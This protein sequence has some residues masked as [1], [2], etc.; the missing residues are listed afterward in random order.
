MSLRA[1]RKYEEVLHKRKPDAKNLEIAENEDGD[2]FLNGV[3]DGVSSSGQ[4]GNNLHC[5]FSGNTFDLLADSDVDISGDAEETFEAEDTSPK[6]RLVGAIQRPKS[7]KP[8]KAGSSQN[9]RRR[10]QKKK[11]DKVAKSDEEWYTVE[12]SRRDSL[13][14][15]EGDYLADV[16]NL[17]LDPTR[18]PDEYFASDDDDEFKELARKLMGDI[19]FMAYP[20]GVVPDAFEASAKASHRLIAVDPRFLRADTELKKLF[21]ARIVENER[22]EDAAIESRQRRNRQRSHLYR[23]RQET[24]LVQPR[25]TWISRA[26]G[27]IMV[28]DDTNNHG[29]GNDGGRIRYYC[30]RYEGVYA[31]VQEEYRS[32]VSS[33]NPNLLVALLRLHPYHVD[34]LLQLSEIFRQMGEPERSGEMLERALH[35][36]E[37]S[38]HRA[39]KPY[40]GSCRLRFGCVENRPLYLAL[41]RYSQLLT[42]RGLHRTALECAKL[43]MNLDPY[44]DPMG[45]LL[46][47]DSLALSS[48]EYEWIRAMHQ[49]YHFVPLEYFPNFAFSSALAAQFRSCDSGK[50]RSGRRRRV[51]GPVQEL[52]VFSNITDKTPLEC[53]KEALLTFP[54]VLRPILKSINLE[55]HE[56]LSRFALFD[57]SKFSDWL[58]DSG[59]LH[60]I[61]HVYAERCRAMWS[62]PSNTQLLLDGAFAAGTAEAGGR[63]ADEKRLADDCLSLRQEAIDFFRK[64]SLYSGAHAIVLSEGTDALPADVIIRD[65][66]LMGAEDAQPRNTV[67]SQVQRRTVTSREAAVAFLETLLPW[68]EARDIVS[69]ANTSNHE[70]DANNNGAGSQQSL[71]EF[72]QNI[73]R[74]DYLDDDVREED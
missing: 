28:P 36:L 44:D 24:F 23:P 40:E 21:G 39:F 38:W 70:P 49:N 3:V 22:R 12:L 13:F 64:C 14:P 7:K 60:R 73:L 30:Y 2:T 68:R 9:T 51:S 53:V 17:S 56:I 10:K 52:P 50:F 16:E 58:V 33:H 31:K 42:Q 43:L 37:S 20:D 59:T 27:L 15:D 61:S 65:N 72:L 54:M 71:W 74:G 63:G 41:M 25:N 11:V 45:V 35:I 4:D 62:S 57:E 55:H 19:V 67:S 26:P 6:D 47:V 1:I 69:G 34:T 32:C 48:K 8:A 29:D 46:L 66:D 5:V 18:I